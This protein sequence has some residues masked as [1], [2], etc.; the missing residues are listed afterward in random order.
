MP[1]AVGY[2][3]TCKKEKEVE[4]VKGAEESAES[5][6][7]ACKCKVFCLLFVPWLFIALFDVR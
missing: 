5:K 6:N 7:I 1:A 2:Q 3:P 4:R